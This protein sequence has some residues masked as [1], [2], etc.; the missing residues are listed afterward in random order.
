[1]LFNGIPSMRFNFAQNI[2]YLDIDWSKDVKA[3]DFIIIECY[4][5]LDPDQYGL[6]WHDPW[7]FKYATALIKRQWG[8]NMKKY[9]GVQLVGG[10]T[11]S[12]QRIYDEAVLEITALEQ[13]L[14]DTYEEPPRM[15]L[16]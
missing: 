16:G 8:I 13:E 2:L 3:G 15:I 12:G 5:M 9:D 7:L 4:R 6:I 11:F 10:I 1:M 14:R